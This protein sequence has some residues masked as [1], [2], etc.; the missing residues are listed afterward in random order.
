M[1]SGVSQGAGSCPCAPHLPPIAYE[2]ESG[3]ASSAPRASYQRREPEK[4]AFYRVVLDN[5][6]TLFEEARGSSEDGSGYPKFVE[7]AMRRYLSCGILAHAFARL[8]C[9][10]C[11]FERVVAYSCKSA[12]CPSC[13]SRRAAEIAA[14][15]V[16]RVLPEAPYRQF[17]LTFPWPMRLP[18]AFDPD[19]LSKT[20]NA[21][22]RTLFAWQRQRGRH[23]G[24]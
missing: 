13:R 24:I 17:V 23:V 10:D 4:T 20:M 21:Y 6:E 5:V 7:K 9:P 18:L 22:L 3:A 14:H 19:F 2:R 1:A 8:R 12:F 16:D 15:L 11:G